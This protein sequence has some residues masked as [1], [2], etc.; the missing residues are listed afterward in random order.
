MH[1]CHV[2]SRVIGEWA[3]QCAK[4]GAL[5]L[6]DQSIVVVLSYILSTASKDKILLNR[7]AQLFCSVN[8]ITIYSA[9]LGKE[10][11]FLV[12]SIFSNFYF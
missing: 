12:T 6:R 3:K 2:Y 9:G 1:K 11:L 5:I 8:C 10:I 7:E 4:S